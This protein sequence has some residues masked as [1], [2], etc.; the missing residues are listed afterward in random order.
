MA[1]STMSIGG[2]ASGLDTE[3]IIRQLLQLERAPI[4]GFQR[5]QAE[6]RHVDD[7]WG[8]VTT[9][10]SSL[11]AAVDDLRK[12]GSFDNFVK[13]GSSDDT[14]VGATV[15]GTPEAGSLS[16]SVE[17][18]AQA[19]QV[20][21]NG[22]TDANGDPIAPLTSPDDL[23]GDGSFTFTQAGTTH[24]VVTDGKTLRQ[25]A[26]E[27]ESLA[28]GVSTQLV[29]DSNGNYQLIAAARSSG[30]SNAIEFDFTTAPP[31]LANVDELQAA[32]NAQLKMGDSLTVQRESNTI[33]DLIDGVRLDLKTAAPGT[34]VT[35]TTEPDK[36]KAVEG[37][38]SLVD[39]AN[40]L[41]ETLDKLTAYDVESN[42]AGALQGDHTARTLVADLRRQL[43]DIVAGLTGD[44]T[45]AGTVGISMTR[46]GQFELDES[47]LRTALDTDPAAVAALFS[48]TD[49]SKGI[50]GT[51]H[52]GVLLWAEGDSSS[53]DEYVARGAIGRARDSATTSIRRFDDRIAEF[54]DRV[55]SREVTLRKQFTAMETALAR[56]Q[57]EGAWL[58][59]QLAGLSGGAS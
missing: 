12:P 27:I 32:L 8:S 16:F 53:S 4:V 24:E 26:D 45:S 1:F 33:D 54:E 55:K 23:V 36:D 47:K 6:L 39:A 40:G 37:V 49:G 58:S 38:R 25:V 43:S 20:A 35:I 5:R 10:L 14:I 9:K 11:R 29:K 52:S 30:L 41:L 3:N 50:A 2:M 34:T 22:G 44:Y 21:L 56:L 48:E 7:A 17:Q 46:E 59:S 31:S 51:L 13:V 18:R 42:K 15:T 57:S 28:P 19:H